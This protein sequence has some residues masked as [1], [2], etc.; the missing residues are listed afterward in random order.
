MLFYFVDFNTFIQ[1]QYAFA[2][3]LIIRL[4][5]FILSIANRHLYFGAINVIYGVINTNRVYILLLGEFLYEFS[6]KDIR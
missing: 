2:I 6:Y 4:D 1:E 3:I 5:N